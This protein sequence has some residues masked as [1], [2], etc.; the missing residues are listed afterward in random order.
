MLAVGVVTVAAGTA[1][2]EVRPQAASG[3]GAGTAAMVVPE[4][5]LTAADT[6]CFKKSYPNCAS[7]EP[8]V[9]Y[10]I[11]SRGDT[12]ACTFNLKATWGDAATTD[13]D[14]GGGT[15]GATLLPVTHTYTK[16]KPFLAPKTYALTWA[17][18]VKSGT[19][20]GGSG[21]L[22][23]ARTCSAKSLTG[24]AWAARFPTSRRLQDLKGDFEDDVTDFVRA[25]RAAG[26]SVDPVATLRPAQRAYL[27]HY[28][29]L[30][31]KK[32]TAAN[33]VPAFQPAKGQDPVDVCWQHTDK[34]G[35]YDSAAS[36]KAAQ[37]LVTA[38]GIDPDL[39]VAP[40][41]NSL[42]TQG[43]A[44]D[45]ATTWSA[46][47]ITITDH[48]GRHVT[49]ATTPRSGLN[50]KLIAVGATYGVIHF[51]QASKDPKHWS[52]TGH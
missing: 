6:S 48:A 11:V 43:R 9:S 2:A 37:A 10:K 4:L 32:Q 36:V 3:S 51:L 29:W 45:M 49:I 31:A 26:I 19:C 18:T 42:H 50:T 8:T 16:P 40:A 30:V 35:K 7:P 20:S 5:H 44:I 46:R 23:F 24:A 39:K 17:V 13:K 27:M 33:K 14:F 15:D 41:L 22:S 1:S 47:S 34:D 52:T 38:F 25:M 21:T 12:T 28:A